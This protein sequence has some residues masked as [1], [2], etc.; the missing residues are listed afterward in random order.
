MNSR[1]HPLQCR[2]GKL[3]GTVAN[4]RAAN[5]AIC[6]CRDCQAFIH[7]LGNVSD[8]LDARG[9]SEIVQTL[10]RNLTFTQGSEQLACL[11]LTAKGLLRWYARCCRTPIG[12][13]LMT[14]KWSF[15]GLLHACLRSGSPS[16][17]ES[18]GPVTAWVHTQSAKGDPK[19]K[20]EG[21]GKS[22]SWFLRTVV[23][24]R[25]NG[26]YRL[27]PLFRAHTG[28]PI[29]VPHVLSAEERARVV[30]AVQASLGAP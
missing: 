4:P 27:T 26:D 9:G 15:I 3:R 12:N 1:V 5:H 16:L 19:P 6:Y 24:A 21:I 30:Q 29:A 14:P 28:A 20:V 11:R 22:I 10:P 18:F 17:E 8:V 7:Y 2:C 13:T 25:F 23:K